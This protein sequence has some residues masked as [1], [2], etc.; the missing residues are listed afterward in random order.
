MLNIINR[1]KQISI[2]IRRRRAP[3]GG[4][5]SDGGLVSRITTYPNVILKISNITPTTTG[6]NHPLQYNLLAFGK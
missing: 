5:Q 2:G 6:I 1:L 3:S 4:E